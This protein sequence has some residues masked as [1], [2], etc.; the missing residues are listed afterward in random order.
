MDLAIED[1]QPIAE[2]IVNVNS[3]L[4][5]QV[6]RDLIVIWLQDLKLADFLRLKKH[7]LVHYFQWHLA[8]IM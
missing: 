2:L 5:D 7:F 8:S 3:Q 6:L 1:W 4:Q